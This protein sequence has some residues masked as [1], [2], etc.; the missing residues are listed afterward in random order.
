M[1]KTSSTINPYDMSLEFVDDGSTIDCIVT[2]NT[3]LF[4][5]IQIAL[6]INRLEVIS[7]Q[8][9]DYSDHLELKFLN[10]LSFKAN[11]EVQQTLQEKLAF[12][13]E[14]NF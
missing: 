7:E 10:D 5:E 13:L 4:D 2:Y 6:F 11:D 8:L 9:V 1:S 3:S 12:S 14:E